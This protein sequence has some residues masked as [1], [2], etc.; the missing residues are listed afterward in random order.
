MARWTDKLGRALGLR[1]GPEA[2]VYVRERDGVL[3]LHIG[4]T[5][6]QSAMRLDDP[7]RLELS[8]TRSM[9]ALLLF[10]P[11]PRR[12]LLVGLGGG[13]LVRYLHARFPGIE[14]R[15]VEIDAEVVRVA[16]ERF[17]LPQQG[18]EVEVADGARYLAGRRAV[19]DAILVDAFDGERAAP[20]CTTR[21]FFDSLRSALA[22]PGVA[23]VNLWDTD[24]RYEL[25]RDR[26]LDAFDGRVALLPSVRPGNVVALGLSGMPEAPRWTDLHECAAALARAGH[27]LEFAEFV[28]DLRRL[29]PHDGERLYV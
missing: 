6:V 12:A 17:G 19:A 8:Y 26:L 25:Y 24:P 14:I 13:A 2:R 1:S 10:R 18:V 3:S 9:M 16:R 27:G 28:R 20:E 22:S 15:A 4:S 5:V 21:P 11:R 7:V 29:N 23:A